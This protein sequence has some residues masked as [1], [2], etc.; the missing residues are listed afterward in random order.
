MLKQIKGF[1]VYYDHVCWYYLNNQWH[2][3]FMDAVI[4]YFRNQWF[5]APLYLF[6]LIFMPSRF[7]KKGWI[8]CLF[9]ILSFSISDQLIVYVIKPF[10]HR[11][12]PCNN[13]ELA[14]VVHSLIT[15]SGFSFPSAHASNHFAMG[16]FS[17]FTLSKYI[18]WIW[19][20]PILW[21][22]TV[23]Y[24]QVYVG[25]HYPLDVIGGGL[26]GGTVGYCASRVF[27]R[28]FELDEFYRVP[29]SKTV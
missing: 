3:R 28:F 18:K 11:T 1:L 19:V 27:N 16:V 26:L 22:L 29:G 13:P 2:N 12:R 5:W 10:F 8:W 6:L 15:A 14:T 21:A 20:L 9:F 24:A 7:G 23:A 17:A 4:P 25:V